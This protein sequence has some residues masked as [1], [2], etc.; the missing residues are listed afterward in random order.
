MV[1]FADNW[2]K[3][4]N[5]ALLNSKTAFKSI[6]T[7]TEIRFQTSFQRK[8]CLQKSNPQNLFQQTT[9]QTRFH[10]WRNRCNPLSIPDLKTLVKMLFQFL[11]ASA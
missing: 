6:F 10:L 9:Q 3:K 1:N 8:Q 7:K 4:E 2:S 11:T 5:A